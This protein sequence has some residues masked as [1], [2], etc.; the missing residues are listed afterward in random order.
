[1]KEKFIKSTI[2]LMIGGIFTKILGMISKI[3]LTRYLGTEGIGV[4]MLILPSFIL[5]LNLASFGFPVSISKMVASLEKNNKRLIFTSLFF[6]MF[7]NILLIIFIIMF[8]KTLAVKLLHNVNCTIPIMSIALVLPFTSVSSIIRSYFFGKEKM[9]PHILSNILEDVVRILLIM[10]LIKKFSYLDLKYQVT[11]VILINI[12]CELVSIFILF[13]FLPKNFVITKRDI[14][15]SKIY[16]KESL[17]ISVP[18]TMTRLVTSV[19]Y[20]FEPIIL[21]NTLHLVGY[22]SHYIH[23]DYKVTKF[24]QNY[25]NPIY[26]LY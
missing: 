11:L 17:S 23:C 16:L 14:Y 22:T 21:T 2:I 6:V 19:C 18:N 8:S 26:T 13:L 3:F 15:P 10:I 20:F 1:M 12:I 9:I 5:F 24:F 25:C 4:Y 7:I